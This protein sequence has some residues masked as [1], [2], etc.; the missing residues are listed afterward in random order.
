M[1]VIATNLCQL[2]PRI[3][4][5]DFDF[6]YK[7]VRF[8]KGIFFVTALWNIRKHFVAFQGPIELRVFDINY[9]ST[10]GDYMKGRRG[11]VLPLPLEYNFPN[12]DYIFS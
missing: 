3:K 2:Y 9:T 1:L 10:S 4:Q 11:G 5:N 8:K 6:G 7:I 12:W